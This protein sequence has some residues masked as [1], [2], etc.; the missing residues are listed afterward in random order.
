[1]NAAAILAGRASDVPLERGD[2]VYVPTRGVTN[3]SRTVG[4][5]LSPL[6][7]AIATAGGAAALYTALDG[8]SGD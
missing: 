7:S 2:I 4:Q 8:S 5:A 3:W 1:V 6:A